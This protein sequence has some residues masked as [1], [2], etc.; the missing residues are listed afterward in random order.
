MMN[1]YPY[2]ATR[3]LPP[4]RTRGSRSRTGTAGRR[5]LYRR[6]TFWRLPGLMAILVLLVLLRG[7]SFRY[8]PISRVDLASPGTP[9]DPSSESTVPALKREQRQLK[10]ALDR[11]ALSGNYI[12]VDVTN[13]RIFVRNDGR[14]LLEAICST[15]SGIRL[16]EGD[17][18]EWEFQTPRGLFRVRQKVEDPLW[19]RPDWAFVEELQPVPSKASDRL[20]AGM[21]GE[22]GLHFG[23]GYLIH[24]TLYER[25]LG[26]SVTH[27]CVRVGRDD[28]RA[29]YEASKIGTAIIIF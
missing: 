27:G 8:E 7:A 26:R 12:V 28:L 15:G 18:R 25:L 6:G 2:E 1:F 24:G 29:I 4:T 10:T 19:R 21:M 3:P 22:Y 5:P 13:N 9:S 20:E 16:R 17:K 11:K 23:N 14:L